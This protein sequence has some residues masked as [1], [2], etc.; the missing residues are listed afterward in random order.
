M[1]P[2]I[3][4]EI[5]NISD[6]MDMLWLEYETNQWT[7]LSYSTKIL[8]EWQELASI[9]RNLMTLLCEEARVLIK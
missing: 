3:T 8:R 4:K 6:K 1:I 5:K 2:K 9:H 7:N